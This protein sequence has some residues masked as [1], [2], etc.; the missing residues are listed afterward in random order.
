MKITLPQ[1]CDKLA[2]KLG[3][4]TKDLR[5]NATFPLGVEISKRQQQ[6]N[7]RN[8]LFWKY[9]ELR[10]EDRLMCLS[11]YYKDLCLFGVDIQGMSPCDKDMYKILDVDYEYTCIGPGFYYWYASFKM[12]GRQAKGKNAK[13]NYLKFLKYVEFDTENITSFESHLKGLTKTDINKGFQ[14]STYYSEQT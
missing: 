8:F 2:K 14:N 6:D 3:V 9:A 4:D 7:P 1:L 10:E 13:Q 12:D 5:V 11:I